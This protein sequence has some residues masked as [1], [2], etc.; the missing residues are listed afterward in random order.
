MTVLIGLL[1]VVIII[2]LIYGTLSPCE[3][4][5]KQIATQAAKSG[6]GQFEYVLFGGFVDRAIDI[7]SP[8]QC[9]DAVF[10]ISIGGNIDD[11]L[12]NTG[13]K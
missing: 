4:L 9:M 7:L 12:K 5:K 10:K 8:I 6:N 11:V 1:I 3:M 2:W 13:L